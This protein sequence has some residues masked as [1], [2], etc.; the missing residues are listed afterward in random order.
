M[1]TEAFL[2]LQFTCYEIIDAFNGAYDFSDELKQLADPCLTLS[3]V[4][5][6]ELSLYEKIL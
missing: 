5:N 1:L 6:I 2:C 3:A 4:Q